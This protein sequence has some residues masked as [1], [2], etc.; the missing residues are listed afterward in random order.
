MVADRTGGD[1]GQAII[2]PSGDVIAGSVGTWAVSYTVGNNGL[3]SGSILRIGS[4]C[5]SDWGTPQMSDPTAPEYLTVRGPEDCLVSVQTEGVNTIRLEVQGRALRKGESIIVVYGDRSYGSPG[6]RAQTFLEEKHYFWIAIEQ[7]PDETPIAL[8]NSPHLRLIGG[9]ATQLILTTPSNGVVGEPFRLHIKAE[10]KWGNPS[11]SYAG[12]VDLTGDG[13]KGLDRASVSC[14]REERGVKWLEGLSASE[15]GVVRI[16]AQDR[17][18]HMS[19]DSNPMLVTVETPSH[20]LHWADP[21]GGQVA[22]NSKIA[23]FFQYARDVSALQFVGYQRNDNSISHEDW[24]VQQRQEQAFYEPGRFVPAPG[25]EWSGKN[26][27][28]GHHNV[29]FRRHGQSVRRS[30]HTGKQHPDDV[31][32]DLTHVLDLYEAYRHADVVITPH[33]GGEH[34]DLNHHEPELEPALEMTSTHGPFEW[35]QREAVERRYKLGFI[36]G[37]D[38]HTGRPGDD[39]PGFQL[40][41]YAK[42]GLAGVY[43]EK[44]TVEGFINAMRSRRV[45]ATTGSRILVD[46]SADGHPI[47]AEYATTK[48]PLITVSVHGTAP[49]E[50]I[51]LFRGLE[52]IHK[53]SADT[54]LI[55]NRIRLIWNG[56]SR[57]TSYSG[58]IWDGRL[59]AEGADID[60]VE[61]LRF[62]SPRS[63]VVHQI[64]DTLAWHAWGCGYPMGLIV[65]LGTTSP[66][67]TL[68]ISASS[69]TI[70][71]PLYGGHGSEGQGPRRMSKAEAEGGAMVVSV[72]GLGSATQSLNLG[73][74]NR[75][76]DVSIDRAPGP[77]SAGFSFTDQGPAAGV[78]PYWIRVR[79]ADLE[80]AWSSPIFVDFAPAT[81]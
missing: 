73:V 20:R 51:E 14:Q 65:E 64:S 67:A 56:A 50:S 11:P 15:A 2:E 81:P 40:R 16:K 18:A 52:L 25:F 33:V 10:D 9:P 72:E 6:S 45:Y 28:G 71:G 46:V 75:R 78:N 49:I 27:V 4:E 5:D 59:Q 62:D 47:G 35:F 7:S 74:L 29:Y 31:G 69:Q 61:K 3:K 70:S 44:L 55:D 77:A 12:T 32:S 37:S 34:G 39:K 23:D 76:V 54:E 19:A 8:D 1:N 38:S 66:K 57:M 17:S 30:S 41:R 24:I 21:H 53:Y 22:L 13:I 68:H 26:W 63:R 80:M 48:P 36:G 43:A 60:Q 42:A 79:Q 58:V